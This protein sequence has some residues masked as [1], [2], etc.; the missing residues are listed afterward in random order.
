VDTISVGGLQRSYQVIRP[1][2]PA[3]PRLPAVVFLHGINADIGWEETRD[4]LLPLAAAGQVVLVYPVGYEESWNAG[5]CCGGAELQDLDDVAFVQAVADRIA[6]DPGV[7]P[8]R[9][10]LAGYSNGGKM[11]YRLVCDDPG[12]FSAVAVVLALPMT[13][14]PSD[15]PSVSLLH[16]AVRDDPELPYQP[17]DL[18]FQSNGVLLTPVTS[19]VGN[20]RNR[21][22]CAGASTQQ[23]TGTLTL[24][25]WS[26]C[27]GGVRVELASYGSGGHE[28]PAGDAATPPAGQI[29]WSFVSGK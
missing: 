19:E 22:G 3:A 7:D 17:G 23:V 27:Q 5:R 21:D 4:G 10:A 15:G 16:V 28:W 20:W 13:P 25:R 24:Q 12:R 1:V 14:C 2:Q 8:A 18:P 11:A 29:I 26:Q 9:I 6:A